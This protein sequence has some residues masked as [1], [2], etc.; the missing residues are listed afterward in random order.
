MSGG[1][2]GF[3]AAGL[4]AGPNVFDGVEVGCGGGEEQSLAPRGRDQGGR[5]RRLVNPGVVQHDDA[6]RRPRREPSFFKINV[7]DLRVATALKHAG[8]HPPA[9]WGSGNDPRAFPP[10]ACHRRVNTFPPWGARPLPIQAVVHAA[11]GAVIHVWGRQLGEFAA[12]APPLHFVAR[13]IL[14]EFFLA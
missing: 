1:R 2:E 4:E 10:F 13:P 12:A 3:A 9:F 6:A 7:P 8:G 11:R 5:G 14:H